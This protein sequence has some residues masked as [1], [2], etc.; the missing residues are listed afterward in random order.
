MPQRRLA[1]SNTI[2]VPMGYNQTT[3]VPKIDQLT[4][5]TQPMASYGSLYD[6]AS[7][8]RSERRT[9]LTSYAA[10][11]FSSYKPIIDYLDAKR[12][13]EHPAFPKAPLTTER[14]LVQYTPHRPQPPPAAFSP[15]DVRVHTREL[16]AHSRNCN[17]NLDTEHIDVPRSAKPLFTSR[18]SAYAARTFKRVQ[19][20][21]VEDK[22]VRQHQEREDTRRF[23]QIM[24]KI[25]HNRARYNA[26]KSDVEISD[27]LKS[28]IRG[29]SASQ[30]T[31][32]II[33]DSERNIRSSRK[34]ERREETVA[35]SMR[36]TS[37]RSV[38]RSG[39]R[40]VRRTINVNF[41][42][43]GMLDHLDSSLSS[44]LHDVKKQLSSFN[45][46]NEDLHQSS[47]LRRVCF[48]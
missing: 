13:G 11:T 38:S 41:E 26:T 34:S 16:L 37:E 48:V 43:D 14:R 45:Q 15:T 8:L 10:D 24:D 2:A 9:P 46:R 32:A 31:A 33:A 39:Q 27:S 20:P 29:K 35:T 44:S 30:I 17:R 12:R 47:R 7:S 6:R 5:R 28:A 4:R 21:T 1:S 22:I 36:Q 23:N 25:A 42:D 40:I 3:V 18:S 19:L